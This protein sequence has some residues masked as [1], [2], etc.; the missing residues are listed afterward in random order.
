MLLYSQYNTHSAKSNFPLLKF[1][2]ELHDFG[3]IKKDK[4]VKFIFKFKNIG[5]LPL[6]IHAVEPNCGCTVA[7]FT[8]IPVLSGKEGFLDVTFDAL[9]LG[10]FQKYVI[11]KSNSKSPVQVLYIK[12][13]VRN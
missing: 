8:K 3:V 9:K 4:P 5:K 10:Q 7:S 13:E 6:I 11:V 2:T 1:S 12:G